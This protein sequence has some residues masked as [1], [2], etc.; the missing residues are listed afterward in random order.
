MEAGDEIAAFDGSICC[1]VTMLPQTI[2]FG[3]FN[4]LVSIAASEKD[5]GFANGYT[6][7]DTNTPNRLLWAMVQFIHQ[8]IRW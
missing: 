8:Q 4:T 6:T 2:V 1:G 7:G 5:A 3:D